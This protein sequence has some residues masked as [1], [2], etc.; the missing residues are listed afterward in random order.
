MKGRQSV[1]A[2]AQKVGIGWIVVIVIVVSLIGIGICW[3]DKVFEL[4]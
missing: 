2:I 3:G 1:G 4:H